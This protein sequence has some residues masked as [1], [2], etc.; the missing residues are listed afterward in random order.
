[1]SGIENAID[2]IKELYADGMACAP[3]A[4]KDPTGTIYN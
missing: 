4:E 1:M 3:V 2:G